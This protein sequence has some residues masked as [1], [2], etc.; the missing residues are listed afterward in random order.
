MVTLELSERC[1]L[2]KVNDPTACAPCKQSSQCANPCGRCELCL[3]RTQ[4]DLPADCALTTES[5][6]EEGQRPC[7]SSSECG[8]DEYCQQGCCYGLLL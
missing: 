1:S 7:D 3:G 4:R 2:A 8:I 5:R 6:C